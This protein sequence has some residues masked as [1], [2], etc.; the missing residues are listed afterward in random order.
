MRNV[1]SD[2][3]THR[4]H[5]NPSERSTTQ[6]E[7]ISRL[8]D[9]VYRLAPD[10]EVVEMIAETPEEEDELIDRYMNHNSNW[11]TD[12]SDY[13]PEK[14]IAEMS[15]DDPVKRKELEAW[16]EDNGAHFI[17]RMYKQFKGFTDEGNIIRNLG[18]KET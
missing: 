14:C 1:R 18:L 13:A 10:L 16:Y 15:G 5:T 6:R 3:R 2:Q 17:T 12:V 4:L 9:T 8:Q 11:S 7:Q